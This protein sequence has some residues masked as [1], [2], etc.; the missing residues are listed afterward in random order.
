L[1]D[2]VL[3]PAN[4]GMRIGEANN[5]KLRDMVPFRARGGASKTG[6]RDLSSV[7][8]EIGGIELAYA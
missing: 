6:E 8:Y 5:L 7:C 3:R 1:S 2:Y 4:S